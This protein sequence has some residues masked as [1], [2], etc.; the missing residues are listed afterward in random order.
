MARKERDEAFIESDCDGKYKSKIFDSYNVTQNSL[1]NPKYGM[2][3]I[4][5][6]L[7]YQLSL[8]IDYNKY[9]NNTCK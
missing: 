8:I 4:S 7:H 3:S 9:N 5:Y 2:Q 1:K 6:S